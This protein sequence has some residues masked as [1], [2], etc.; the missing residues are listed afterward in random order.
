MYITVNISSLYSLVLYASCVDT[1]TK[2]LIVNGKSR[3]MGV[4]YLAVGPPNKQQQKG[5]RET[6]AKTRPFKRH[7]IFL[8]RYIMLAVIS[9]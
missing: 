9:L 4:L 2:V 8:C 5:N 6:K 1:I 7:P 3:I